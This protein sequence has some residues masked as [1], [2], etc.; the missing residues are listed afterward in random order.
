MLYV[1]MSSAICGD[2]Q[3]YMLKCPVLFVEMSSVIC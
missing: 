2:V 3:R 1:E